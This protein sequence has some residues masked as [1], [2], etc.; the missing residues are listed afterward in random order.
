MHQMLA[1]LM[2]EP[3]GRRTERTE[4]VIRR[5]CGCLSGVGRAAMESGARGRT[6]PFDSALVARRQTLL[7]EL[8][9]ATHGRLGVLGAGWS[10]RL[11]TSVTEEL[12][13]RSEDAFRKTIEE[14]LLRIADTGGELSAFNEV[15]TV[16]W[17]QLIPCT[18][19]EPELRSG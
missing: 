7:A 1:K 9:R 14:M 10:E 6:L 4:L 11:L 13:G 17:R 18:A 19:A 8:L 2:D 15:I 3:V 16:L 12:K 5:S